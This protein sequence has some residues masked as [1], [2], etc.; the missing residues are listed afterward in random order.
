MVKDGFVVFDSDSAVLGW[1]Q[2]AYAAALDITADPDAR[3]HNLRHAQTWFVGVD[4]LP[5]AEDGSIGDVPLK[6]PWGPHL[7]APPRWHR[8]QLSVVYPGYPG[9]DTGESDANHRYRI[10]RFAAH[11]DGLLPLGPQRRRF[12]REPHAF[13]LGLPLNMAE[14]A[15]LVV[16]PG[17][18]T[19]MGDAFREEIAGRNPQ[20]IDLTE[21]YQAAR[22]AVF[23]TIAPLRVQAGP[24]QSI[25]LHRHLLH[26]V[27]PWDAALD[28][29]AEG[30]MIAYFHPQF[31]AAEWLAAS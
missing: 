30:R 1:A 6:G 9:Q 19:V 14:A 7:A 17:S 26:G 29:P 23:D 24:G 18:H 16:W 10:K 12:L 25:L 8:A 2:A 3:A 15:P 11:V 21:A 31:T 20:D 5:N 27:A 4:A 13:V 28:G 22:R